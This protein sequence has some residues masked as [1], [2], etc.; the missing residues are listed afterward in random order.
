MLGPSELVVTGSDISSQAAAL[1]RLEPL[2]ARQ[3][4]VA[5][6]LGP[7]QVPVS[8]QLG[9]A[10][11]AS[12]TAARYVFFLRTDPLGS[13]GISAVETLRGRLAALLRQAGLSNDRATVAGDTALSAD[14]VDGTMSS[15]ERVIPAA[16]LAV[17]LVIS[18][19]LRSLVAPAYLVLTALLGVAASLGLTV[20]VLQDL[21][22]YGQI[23]YYVVFMV[24]VMLISLGSDYNV[25]LVGRIWQEGRRRSFLD[26]VEIGGTRAARPI[27]TAGLVLAMSFALLA[28]VPLRPFREM[29]FGM[30]VGLLIDAFIIRTIL[31]PALVSLVG[32]RSS[33]P[34]HALTETS[35]APGPPGPPG[36]RPGPP[37]GVPGRHPGRCRATLPAEP[38]RG[39]PHQSPRPKGSRQNSANNSGANPD[40]KPT[41]EIDVKD[42]EAPRL[43]APGHNGRR[44]YSYHQHTLPPVRQARRCPGLARSAA[45]GGHAVPDPGA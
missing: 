26:A 21:F 14:I 37:G 22:G 18:L 12:G 40:P 34:G 33:W 39:R 45:A 28:I 5:Q 20:Y 6:V 1:R 31:V 10:V 24:G 27:N 4:D 3:P 23:A 13:K 16:L 38:G 9:F 30:A 8:R 44:D 29:A 19:F 2:L 17:F 7:G 35:G 43:G 42:G 11:A 36:E 41:R 15:L 25:F 32:V